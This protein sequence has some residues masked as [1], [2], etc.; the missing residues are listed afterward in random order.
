MPTNDYDVLVVGSGAGGSAAAWRLTKLGLKVACIERGDWQKPEQYPSTG[1]DVELKK[2]TKYSYKPS[3]RKMPSDYL[4][5]TCNSDIDIANFNGVGG[6]TVLFSGHFPRFHPSDFCTE[7]LDGVGAD[8]PISYA[9]LEPY[10]TANDKMMRVSG[11]SGDPAYPDINGLLPPV[12]IGKYGEKIAEGFN[13]LGWHWWPSYAAIS[14][15]LNVGNA[16]LNL[17]PCNTGCPQGSKSSTDVTYLPSAIKLGLEV[18]PN[19]VVV[20]IENVSGKTKGVWVL[21]SKGNKKFISSKV[22]VLACNAIGTARLLLASKS[23]QFPFG[24]A[25]NSGLVGKNLMLH[26]LGYAEGL[27]DEPL[28]LD[29]GPQGCCIYSHEFYETD[30]SRSFK[31][32]YTLQVL[33]G[34]NLVETAFSGIERRE[35]KLGDTFV[36]DVLKLH[37]RRGSITVICED[38]PDSTNQVRLDESRVDRDGMPVVVV[39]YKMSLNSKS[40]M[41]HGLTQAKRVLKASGFKKIMAFGPV[42]DAGWHILGTTKM[43]LDPKTSVV[44]KTGQTHDVSGLYIADGSVFPSSSGVNPA[45]TIQA[46]ALYIADQIYTE[47]FGVMTLENDIA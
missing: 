15:S 17:G 44:N 41:S 8:W 24:L 6:A 23:S 30:E 22:V 13:Q 1:L 32:G 26:P 45:S 42:K 37:R 14:T 7:S 12:P 5:D 46:V 9:D 3:V 28:D 36:S 40:M 2:R 31:R 16:C 39:D 11:L 18:I 33:R 47:H 43:G 29:K 25:N 20:K 27:F 19:T 34:A 4:I 35:V 38:L 21:D 10:F